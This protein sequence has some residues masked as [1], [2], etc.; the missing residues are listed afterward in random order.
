M[1]LLLPQ[2]HN[3][4]ACHLTCCS[5]NFWVLPSSS[6]CETHGT[7]SW[8][9]WGVS[10]GGGIALLLLLGSSWAWRPEGRGLALPLSVLSSRLFG[11][12][13]PRILSASQI[14]GLPLTL[15]FVTGKFATSDARF[16]GITTR[17]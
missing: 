1:E 16:P 13:F 2:I 10:R 14:R 3:L 7:W 4:H 6:G 11:C 12:S 8:T 9:L 17:H 15:S 5:S